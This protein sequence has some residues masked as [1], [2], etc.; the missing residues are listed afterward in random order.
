[1]DNSVTVLDREE[2][3][4]G[5]GRFEEAVVA[6]MDGQPPER[7]GRLYPELRFARIESANKP[8]GHAYAVALGY[9]RWWCVADWRVGRVDDRTDRV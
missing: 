9:R 6:D 3:P 7:L 1:M 4:Y 5:A 8:R 2:I